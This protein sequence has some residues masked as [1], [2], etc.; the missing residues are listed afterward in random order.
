[1]YLANLLNVLYAQLAE[2][3]SNW[4]NAVKG[5]GADPTGTIDSIDALQNAVN[6][7]VGK[8]TFIPPGVYKTSRTLALPSDTTIIAYG[9]VIKPVDAGSFPP[10]A[11]INDA[12]DTPGG[13]TPSSRPI[14]SNASPAGG[15][16]NIA[17]YGLKWIG[18]NV[19]SSNMH[20]L[21][22][23]NVTNL[24]I[25]NCSTEECLSA[26]AVMHSTDVRV[27]RNTIR[28]FRNGGV[29]TWYGCKRVQILHNFIENGNHG[30]FCTAEPT[31]NPAESFIAED[32][33]IAHN[34]VATMAGN[35][36]WI[37][38]GNSTLNRVNDL[39]KRILCHSNIIRDCGTI[40]IILERGEDCSIK[41]NLILNTG[42][43]GIFLRKNVSSGTAYV[44]RPILAN[45][46]IRNVGITATDSKF[47]HMDD[48]VRNALVYGNKGTGTNHT[49]ALYDRGT[50]TGL[51]YYSNDFVSG[52]SGIYNVLSA[53]PKYDPKPDGTNTIIQSTS[54]GVPVTLF[55]AAVQG[56]VWEVILAVAST[57]ATA[58]S[59]ARFMVYGNSTAPK[60]VAL[61]TFGTITYTL[62][63]NGTNV[64][65]TSSV[66]TSIS[67]YIWR[68]V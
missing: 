60:I 24:T 15:N 3:A 27:I 52:T 4:V 22:V 42:S 21:H 16:S 6:A 63:L 35:G 33:I 36:I 67:R 1:M 68:K 59:Y 45:N 25:E 31:D 57:G 34:I 11:P 38:G 44:D 13:I 30:I 10:Y 26:I 37:G 41:D 9:A 61:E 46:V 14:L 64:E 28:G 66:A 29:D 18:N 39:Q 40:G 5:F 58:P 54:A 53:N 47:I 2:T 43:H 49:Y 20:G 62:G 8:V 50:N 56:G 65:A 17:I 23:F 12:T 7:G 55:N 32:Y 48:T 19:G 51:T